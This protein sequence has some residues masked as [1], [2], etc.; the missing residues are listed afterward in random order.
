MVN[1]FSPKAWQKNSPQIYKIPHKCLGLIDCTMVSP[2]VTCRIQCKTTKNYAFRHAPTCF[3]VP[4]AGK[5][6]L[7]ARG[8]KMGCRCCI[9]L[10]ISIFLVPIET[11]KPIYIISIFRCPHPRL[12]QPASCCN[13][14]EFAKCVPRFGGKLSV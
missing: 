11:L 3:E 8:W 13:F 4:R 7:G 5:Q 1:M 2:M 10:S 14:I 9:I 12:S 6:G